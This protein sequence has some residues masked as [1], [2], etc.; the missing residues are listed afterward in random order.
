MPAFAQSLIK[1]S[2][3]SQE[4]KTQ[5]KC[6]SLH[7]QGC[8][9]V[10]E[11]HLNRIVFLCLCFKNFVYRNTS[12]SQNKTSLVLILAFR[13]TVNIAFPPKIIPSKRLYSLC[14]LN[15]TGRSVSSEITLF[16]NK[17]PSC[18]GAIH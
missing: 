6:S 11:L 13:V 14:K 4:H 18:I 5:T 9:I 7:A 17:S 3:A 15:W 2:K 8:S 1:S 12:V 16:K 10:S